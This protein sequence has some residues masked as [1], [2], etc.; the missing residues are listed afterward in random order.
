MGAV[1]SAVGED[2]TDVVIVLPK[3]DHDSDDEKGDDDNS[4]TFTV[5]DVRS[6][7]RSANQNIYA[8]KVTSH[9]PYFNY[10]TRVL[11]YLE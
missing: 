6:E 7:C 1:G 11:S 9:V 10:M 4:G 5:K 3:R 8:G 2:G